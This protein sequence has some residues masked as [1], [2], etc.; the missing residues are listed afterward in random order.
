MAFLCSNIHANKQTNSKADC[1]YCLLSVLSSS[2]WFSDGTFLHTH[3][4]QQEEKPAGCW[5]VTLSPPHQTS[6]HG[7]FLTI[8]STTTFHP[9]PPSFYFLRRIIYN[10]ILMWTRRTQ[11]TFFMHPLKRN[12]NIIVTFVRQYHVSA[13]YQKLNGGAIFL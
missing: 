3:S 5:H 12:T 7:G 10:I 8:A 11:L 6:Y 4:V 2:L 9:F 1:D 13:C